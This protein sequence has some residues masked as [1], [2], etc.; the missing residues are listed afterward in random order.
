MKLKIILA[1]IIWFLLSHFSY[2][3]IVSLE[4]CVELAIKQHPDYQEQL[5]NTVIADANFIG[6]A[7]G[8]WIS[9]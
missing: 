7:F 6:E 2:A 3:Q 8:N 4:D 1:F 9:E 5:L